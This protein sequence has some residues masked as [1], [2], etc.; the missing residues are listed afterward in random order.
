[1]QRLIKCIQIFQS[2]LAPVEKRKRFWF[3]IIFLSMA[4][5]AVNLPFTVATISLIF[6]CSHPV[7]D[8]FICGGK[9]CS[10]TVPISCR[11]IMA[12]FDFLLMFPVTLLGGPCMSLSLLCL[13]FLWNFAKHASNSGHHE[14]AKLLG[15]TRLDMLY[16]QTQIFSIFCNECCKA[17]IWSGIQF[18]GAVAVVIPLYSLVI[19][20]NQLSPIFVAVGIFIIIT[21]TIFCLF[22]FELGSR[23][24]SLSVCIIKRLRNCKRNS[25]SW[26]FGKSCRPI[27]LKVGHFHKMDRKLGSSF[28]RFCVQRTV[29]L[30][31]QTNS[32]SRL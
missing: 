17:Y 21:T 27:V 24:Q 31:V 10:I 4:T 13:D 11:V 30:V 20:G 15:Q 25:L 28:V 1:M 12:I 32:M 2:S 26:K 23:P 14:D 6:P 7:L 29:F 9:A 19:F 3:N 5:M 8:W 22:V 18:N 16:R